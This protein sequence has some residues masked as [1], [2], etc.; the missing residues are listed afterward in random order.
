MRTISITMSEDLYQLKHSVS[1]RQINNLLVQRLKK[2][3]QEGRR[4]LSLSWGSRDPRPRRIERMGR[5]ERRR[6]MH[7]GMKS[8]KIILQRGYGFDLKTRRGEVY[9]VRMTQQLI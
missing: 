3:Y 7:L 2:S 6:L 5:F 9:W 1:S 8:L 4:T